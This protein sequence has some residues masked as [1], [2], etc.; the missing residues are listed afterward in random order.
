MYLNCKHIFFIIFFVFYS[1]LLNAQ[2]A[3][4]NVIITVT[5]IGNT[6]DIA[7]QVA[8]RSA[9]EQAF[10]AFISSKTDVLNDKIVSD[11]ITSVSNGNIKS[12][13]SINEFQLPDSTWSITLKVIVSISKLQSF[14]EAKGYSVSVNGN[15]FASNIRQQIFNEKAEEM[16]IYN[17]FSVLHEYYQKSFDYNIFAN[18]PISI[19]ANNLNWKRKIVVSAFLNVNIDFCNK[20]LISTLSSLCLTSAEVESY[21]KL[22]KSVYKISIH[23]KDT[24]EF[25]FRNSKSV[26]LIKS[27]YFNLLFYIESFKV[28]DG[29]NT[30]I[31]PGDLYLS[32]KIYN[33]F[34]D[35]KY[36][37][38]PL[39]SVN[40]TLG[41]FVYFETRTLNEIEKINEYKVAPL[42]AI[43]K[44][45]YGGYL[46][47]ESNECGIVASIY[48]LGNFS[49][50]DANKNCFNYSL[51]GFADWQIPSIGELKL[52][53]SLMY[54][55]NL[56]YISKATYWSKNMNDNSVDNY[57]TYNFENKIENFEF[58][59]EKF[60]LRPIRRFCVNSNSNFIFDTVNIT[61]D[62]I[63]NRFINTIGGE[64]IISQIESYEAHYTIETNGVNAVANLFYKNNKIKYDEF[65]P[66]LKDD[67]FLDKVLITSKTN[68]YTLSNNSRISLDEKDIN[69]LY[70]KYNLNSILHQTQIGNKRIYLGSDGKN[71]LL[72]L[73][74]YDNLYY[75]E[76]YNKNSGLKVAEELIGKKNKVYIRIEYNNYKEVDNF[77]GYMYPTSIKKYLEN[78]LIAEYF[79]K[80]IYINKDIDDSVFTW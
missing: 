37:Y 26:Q 42:G 14:V 25:Y 70:I 41:Q 61:A 65:I 5:G 33:F 50:N 7:K 34:K 48:D 58:K 72:G 44:V 29:I 59:N 8:L 40:D 22:N 24:L 74:S 68:G 47:S 2:E 53:D 20:Y 6:Q 27:L 17:M 45:K 15:Y 66:L 79:L 23:N 18:D 67:N 73:N 1:Q 77:S 4:Q 38:Y 32:K 3:D 31:R 69:D 36:N 35:F 13:T 64:N 57:N 54:K 71:Y 75:K 80:S 78:E 9:I 10:G 11:Q 76:Y 30:S 28:D 55:T 60:Y 52:M 63:Y 39:Y 46:L 12:F 51:N 56:G 16:A 19:D 49:W 62:N 21:K 43:S